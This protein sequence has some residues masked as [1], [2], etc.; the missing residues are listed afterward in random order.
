LMWFLHDS[1]NCPTPPPTPSP[2][3][4][5]LAVP[6]SIPP[7]APVRSFLRF[8]LVAAGEYFPVKVVWEGQAEDYADGPFVIGGWVAVRVGVVWMG[9]QA[10]VREKLTT[11]A[12][13]SA[14]VMS[15]ERGMPGLGPCACQGQADLSCPPH[16]ACPSARRLRASQ[17]PASG[18]MVSR[19]KAPFRS[20]CWQVVAAKRL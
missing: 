18:N 20:S 2:Q 17:R 9:A 5:L 8:S 14:C 13:V 6:L 16:R 7:P 19:G 1:T 15:M 3:L 11:T 12:V 4:L 10:L